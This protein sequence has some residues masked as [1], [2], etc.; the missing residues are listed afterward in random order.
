MAKPRHQRPKI[1]TNTNQS[2]DGRPGIVINNNPFRK[3][4]FT[5]EP[6]ARDKAIIELRQ[7]L[8]RKID[9]TKSEQLINTAAQRFEGKLTG[10]NPEISRS[11]SRQYRTK[12]EQMSREELQGECLDSMLSH[13][14]HGASETDIKMMTVDYFK[15]DQK[16]GPVRTNPESA[17]IMMKLLRENPPVEE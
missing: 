13:L 11:F 9:A 12:L 15:V 3:I 10:I 6:S 2:Q 14:T 5:T 8:K 16:Y 4:Y 7:A 17:G 1:T